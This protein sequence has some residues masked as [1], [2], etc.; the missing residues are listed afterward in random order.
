MRV[1][2]DGRLRGRDFFASLLAPFGH[3]G[4]PPFFPSSYILL[5]RGHASNERK[6][7]LQLENTNTVDTPPSIVTRSIQYIQFTAPN[8]DA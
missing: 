3:L 5:A 2:A 7:P 8:A 4:W 1:D 6:Q